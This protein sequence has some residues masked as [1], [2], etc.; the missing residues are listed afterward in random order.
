MHNYW[1]NLLDPIAMN[2]ENNP[3]RSFAIGAGLLGSGAIFISMWSLA[4]LYLTKAI[5]QNIAVTG[6]GTSM[7]GATL[8]FT[9]WHNFCCWSANFRTDNLWCTFGKTYLEKC[10]IN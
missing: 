4:R 6:L 7:I 2:G 3:G 10:P 8:L 9:P 5:A 1:C